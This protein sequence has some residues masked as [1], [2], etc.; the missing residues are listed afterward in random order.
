MGLWPRAIVVTVLV[1]GCH[2]GTTAQSPTFRSET[3]LVNLNVT[4]V[5]PN[6][7][8]VD[9][10]TRDQFQV[11]EDGVRQTLKFF[12]PGVMPLDVVVLLDTSG[13]MSE[14]I[15]L[16]RRA[17][18]R[19]VRALGREDRV[20][21]MG[22]ANNLRVLQSLTDDK[23]LAIQSIQS[24]RAGGRTPL[25]VSIYTALSELRKSRER[26]EV[27]ARRQ[28]IVVLSD[29]VD[30]LRRHRPGAGASVRARLPVI[31]RDP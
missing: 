10:L 6:S 4:V 26:N 9:G 28:A 16:V 18:T 31:E 7:E 19:F 3:E 29:G 25:Y 14:S 8:P 13:S 15:P 21:V 27:D 12:A 30:T 5:G 17:A 23:N 22:I 24:T 2:L 1:S 11:F 20:V